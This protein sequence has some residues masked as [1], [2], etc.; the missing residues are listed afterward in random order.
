MR[1][2]TT[3]GVAWS[4]YAMVTF[5]SPVKTAEPI[6]MP[7]GRVTRMGPRNHCITWG[8]HRTNLFV[9]AKG[10]KSAMRPFVNILTTC[11]IYKSFIHQEMVA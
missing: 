4:V 2:T 11:Y 6:E 1:P 3:D 7:F 8:Q 5:V 10:D 9:A